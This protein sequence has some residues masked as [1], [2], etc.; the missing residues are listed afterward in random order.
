MAPRGPGG[1]RLAAQGGMWEPP[2]PPGAPPPLQGLGVRTLLSGPSPISSCDCLD[3]PAVLLPS[4]TTP[5][6][7]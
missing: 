6:A 3:C 7:T 4:D 1:L 2:G 5:S